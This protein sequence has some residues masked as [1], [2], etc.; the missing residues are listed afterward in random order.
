M[1]RADIFKEIEILCGLQ[2]K[3][4]VYL[5]EFFEDENR[6]SIIV[7]SFVDEGK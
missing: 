6:V 5:K 2:H 1:D 3:N 4:V 7:D